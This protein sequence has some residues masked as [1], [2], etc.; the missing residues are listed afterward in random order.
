VGEAKPEHQAAS[1]GA[2]GAGARTTRL[3][4]SAP[5]IGSELTGSLPCLTCGYELKGLSIRGLCP[6][7]G[8]A[9]RATI[10]YKVDPQAE[11]FRP[12]PRP[13]VLAAGLVLWSGGALAAAAACWLLRALD[14]LG[15]L[16][17]APRLAMLASWG[18][19]AAVVASGIGAIALVR[20]MPGAPW[21]R[22]LHASLSVLAYVPLA[23]SLRMILLE[24]DPTRSAPY[25]AGLPQADRLALRALAA[26]CMIVVILGLRPGARD[27]V[28]R[29]MVMRTG[30]VDR[31]TLLGMVGVAALGLAGDGVRLASLGVAW[32][33]PQLLNFGGSVIVVVASALLT[34]GLV[35]AA[36]D[37][38][39][40]ARA[41][42]IPSP[43]LRQVL[44]EPAGPA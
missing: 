15:S 35:G 28:K 31:Q 39:R 44:G 33:D 10:L 43:S 8:T 26:A 42:L 38:W 21:S 32:T 13:R 25:F 29:S 27:L 11:E 6:E 18:A 4:A 7:C 3:I 30:R 5:R 17:G 19:L 40:I 36:V 22:T 37:S 41:V 24:I 9:V 16:A 14:M 20:P 34:L 23:W 1:A 12:I 2:G